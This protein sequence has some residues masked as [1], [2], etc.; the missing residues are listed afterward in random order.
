MSAE[1][2]KLIDTCMELLEKQDD[3]IFRMSSLLKRYVEEL[4]HARTIAG[5]V[6]L[7]DSLEKETEAVQEDI[8]RYSD[9]Y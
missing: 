3:I 5:I 8:K 4:N 7:D 6:A 1:T 9:Q 2:Q